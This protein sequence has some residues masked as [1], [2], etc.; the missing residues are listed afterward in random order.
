MAPTTCEGFFSRSYSALDNLCLGI[1]SPTIL[2][3]AGM[4]RIGGDPWLCDASFGWVCHYHCLLSIHYTP[5]GLTQQ[6]FC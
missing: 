2:H 6:G 3:L 1:G 5:F 4:L